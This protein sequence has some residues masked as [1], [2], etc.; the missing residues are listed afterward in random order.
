MISS[1][2]KAYVIPIPGREDEIQALRALIEAC[3]CSVICQDDPIDSF[4]HCVEEADVVVI[5]ICPE[6][7]SDRLFEQI[8]EL[9]SKLG[10]RIV[11]V[12]GAGV[13]LGELPPS[14]HRYGDAVI[15]ANGDEIAAAVCKGE[16]PWTTPQGTPRPAPKTPRH[17]KR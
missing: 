7:A 8:I 11:G 17:K 14:I 15:R 10:K 2:A 5:L 6:T 13:N 16:S 9:A 4:D 3:G 12:W 1:P